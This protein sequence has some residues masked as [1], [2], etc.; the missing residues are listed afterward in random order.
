MMAEITSGSLV[1][2]LAS[3]CPKNGNLC[4]QKEDQKTFKLDQRGLEINNWINVMQPEW[5]CISRSTNRLFKM[6]I[7]MP[8]NYKLR[9]KTDHQ[10]RSSPRNPQYSM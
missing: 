1:L 8:D 4:E 5:R 10:E 9:T 7:F 2:T 6:P 3:A